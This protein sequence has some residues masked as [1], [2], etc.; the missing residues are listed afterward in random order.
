MEMK[1]GRLPGHNRSSHA[2]SP[3]AVKTMTLAA[4]GFIRRF[5]LHVL[6][7][8]FRHIRYDGFLRARRRRQ[9]FARCRALVGSQPLAST[10]TPPT[11]AP[12]LSRR[13]RSP[14]RGLPPSVPG[15]SSSGDAD[16]RT[17]PARPADRMPAARH[18]SVPIAPF[19]HAVLHLARH[20]I[21]IANAGAAAWCNPF[22][23]H[24]RGEPHSSR[25]RR[26]PALRRRPKNAL[27]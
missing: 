12:R 22:F 2:D 7:T 26:A 16:R 25:T 18:P 15:P 8:G 14:H 13:R 27:D 4:G 1:K 19:H 17:A 11:S 24:G 23:S 9:Q 5:V 3:R 10:P 21:S 6:P 20:S